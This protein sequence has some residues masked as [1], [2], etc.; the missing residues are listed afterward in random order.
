MEFN[1]RIFLVASV[2]SLVIGALSNV[3]PLLF[4]TSDLGPET[5]AWISF[6]MSAVT[7]FVSPVLLFACF[8]LIG[9][10]MDLVAEFRSVIVPLFLGSLAG[11]L[12]G[13]FSSQIVYIVWYSRT[14]SWLSIPWIVWYVFIRVFS[15]EFFVGFAALSMAYIVRKRSS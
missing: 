9:G 2:F 14:L 7:F 6:A 13:Y 12:I 3:S 11:H 4:W 5:L 1:W 10:K 15:Y 8:Y